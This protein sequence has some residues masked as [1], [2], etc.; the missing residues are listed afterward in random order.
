MN[1]KKILSALFLILLA[2]P[3]YSIERISMHSYNSDYSLIPESIYSE[4]FVTK[5]KTIFDVKYSYQSVTEIPKSDLQGYDC[6]QILT[7]LDQMGGL[8]KECFGVSYIDGYTGERK[9]LF[10]KS[11]YD[12]K[13][14]ELYIKDKAA[15][16]L[17]FNLDINHFTS[18]ESVYAV[19]AIVSRTP[20]NI[21]VRDIKKGEAAIFVLMQENEESV[22]LYVLIQSSFSPLKHWLLTSAIE[23]A[24]SGRVIELQNWFYRM[25]A[26]KTE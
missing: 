1:R 4:A 12:T 25:L 20:S 22:K 8:D 15:G 11:R 26:G 9:A 5:L 18:S 16:G 7:M 19:T 24:I 13:T 17:Y 6:E 21:F 10:R 3:F 2:L 14:G 23:S